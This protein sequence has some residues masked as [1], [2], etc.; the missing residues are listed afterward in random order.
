MTECD[1]ALMKFGSYDFKHSAYRACAATQDEDLLATFLHVTI[2]ATSLACFVGGGRLSMV[3]VVTAARRCGNH[4][5][6]HG[7]RGNH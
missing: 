3:T 5:N 4:G 2:A 6:L 7:N 1:C